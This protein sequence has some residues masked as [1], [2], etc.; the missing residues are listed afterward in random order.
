MPARVLVVDDQPLNVRVLEAKL[1]SEY[2]EVTTAPDGATALAMMN[3]VK[4]DIVLL[5]VMMPGMDG[6]TV[7]RR[8]KADPELAH[9]PV[10]MVTALSDAGDRVRGLEAGADDF[11][12]KPINDIAMFARVRSLLRLKLVLDEL[13]LRDHTRIQ[14]G[15]VDEDGF[16]PDNGRDAEVLV[17]AQPS[18]TA[19]LI[20][21]VLAAEDRVTR[22]A[23]AEAALAAVETTPFDLIVVE[24]DLAGTDG[25]R[26]CSHL[27]SR[28][29]SRNVPILMVVE[30]C[31]TERLAKGLDLGV[32]D[33][34]YKPL[35]RGELIARARSQIR[36]K[37]YQDRLHATYRRSMSL[38]VTDSLTGL[39]NRRYLTFHLDASLRR[40]AREGKSLA[41]AMID[42]DHFKAVNDALGHP[43]GDE[44]LREVAARLKR[45]IRASDL[46][47]R[48]GG[49]EF[50]VV[51]PDTDLALAETVTSRL[52]GNIANAPIV[53]AEGQRAEITVSIGVAVTVGASDTPE[54]LL[55]RA[56]EALYAAKRG[57]R[58]RVMMASA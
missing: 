17:A 38:A 2:Y 21:T 47:A 26:L 48:L 1:T 33:Y 49:E 51:M 22:V 35:D 18:G 54:S 24:L 15:A 56:D 11:L 25:L 19:T 29:A 13:R 5:D 32:N 52:R 10:V 39:Y 27:R 16:S 20:G 34:I 41:V 40:L 55:K 30:E 31:D 50:V 3:D 14:L 53:L 44:V 46:P 9:I 8:I 45:S 58:N 6:F 4:P 57:G 37:R 36:H 7:C 12:T 43:A 42:L 23:D 28:D